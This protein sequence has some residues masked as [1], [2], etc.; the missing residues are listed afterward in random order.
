MDS[1]Q[2]WS[3]YNPQSAIRNPTPMSLLTQ[4]Y[5]RVYSSGASSRPETG[6]KAGD[7]QDQRDGD[8]GD[9]VK[10]RDLPDLA[11]EQSRRQKASR[12]SYRNAYQQK[13]RAALHDHRRDIAGAG[14]ERYSHA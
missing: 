1:K 9:R 10:R 11:G 3:S 2:A 13:P 8:E 5:Y 6:L 14:A 7:E 4:S 12:Q